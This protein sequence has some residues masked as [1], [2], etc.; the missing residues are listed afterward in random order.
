M[1]SFSNLRY[2]TS[3]RSAYAECFV[4]RGPLLA[5]AAPLHAAGRTAAALS[6]LASFRGNHAVHV[7]S[8][9][10]TTLVVGAPAAILPGRL[11]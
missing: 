6:E 7:P 11:A 9:P 2:L 8:E 5:L 10:L 4:V 3:K 1:A